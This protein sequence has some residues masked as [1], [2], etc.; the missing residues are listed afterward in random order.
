[1]RRLIVLAALAGGCSSFDPISFLSPND[2]RVLGVV[3]DPPEAAAGQ[4]TTVTVIAPALADGTPIT[5]DWAIC[6]L[7]PPPGTSE[8]DP[9]CLENDT[10]PFLTPIAAT[11]ATAQ[12]TMPDVTNPLTLGIPD[13]TG[14]FYLPVRIRA[15][16][17]SQQ[18]DT[19]FGLRLSLPDLPANHNPTIQSAQ[20]VEPPLDAAPML[21]TELS[22]D[23]ANPTPVEAGSDTTLRL[24]LTPDSYE[25]F[26]ELE[27]TPPNQA[28]VMVSEQPRFFWYSDAG[29]I[30][31]DVTGQAQ[32]DVVLSVG[33]KHAPAEG[34]TINLW[35]VAQDDRGGAAF[36]HRFLIVH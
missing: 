22:A 4:T 35:V 21:V 32:P 18:V 3:A 26:P 9:D 27:G 6:T 2:L 1:M 7:S 12:V 24:T 23:P 36:T 30:S 8:V 20:E 14:G 29:A 15:H 25:M 34:Q 16:A 10:A 28:V 19:I 17:G 31:R 13:V 11:G 33:G 5:F